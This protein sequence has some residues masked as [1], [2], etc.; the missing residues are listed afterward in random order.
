MEWWRTGHLSP[1]SSVLRKRFNEAYLTDS[2]PARKNPSKRT[3]K[4]SCE[5]ASLKLSDHVQDHQ[6]LRFR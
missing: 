4:E 6:R 5:Q 2:V 3:L 1:I